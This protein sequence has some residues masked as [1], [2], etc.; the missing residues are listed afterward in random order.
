MG[1]QKEVD[2]SFLDIDQYALDDEWLGHA[3]LYGEWAVNAADARRDLDIAKAD[4]DVTKAEVDKAIRSDPETYGLVKLTETVISS[5]VLLQDD[6]K[7]A[8]A[9]VIEARHELEVMQGMVSALDHRK[10]ALVHLVSLFLSEYYA[11]PTARKDDKEKM[12][13]V[14]KRAVRRKGRDR[15]NKR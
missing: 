15:S 7:T 2:G 13:E 14:E 4:L 8:Q 6:V 10:A 5:T 9:A 11:K 12:D 1:K 3:Q